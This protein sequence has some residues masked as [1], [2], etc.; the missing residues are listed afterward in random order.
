MKIGAGSITN[1]TSGLATVL[2]AP[3]TKS[4][5]SAVAFFSSAEQSLINETVYKSLL[6]PA[7]VKKIREGRETKASAFVSHFNDPIKDYSVQQA[8][9]DV[10]RYHQTCSFMYGLR[11]A[12]EEGEKLAVINQI[13]RLEK[14]IEQ[15]TAKK[16]ARELERTGKKD[17]NDKVLDPKQDTTYK[18]YDAQINAAGEK[19]KGLNTLKTAE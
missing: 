6:T 11:K 17:E 19:L 9:W 16:D 13:S 5:L 1:L 14:R 10:T 4:A 18:L 8:L 2:A 7:V 15:L 12:L 3:A